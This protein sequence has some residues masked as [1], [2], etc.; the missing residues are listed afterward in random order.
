MTG[1]KVGACARF[2]IAARGWQRRISREKEGVE[3]GRAREVNKN[4]QGAQ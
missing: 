1:K 3:R 4:G 2:E